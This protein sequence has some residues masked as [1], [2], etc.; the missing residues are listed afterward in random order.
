VSDLDP[1]EDRGG[2]VEGLEAHPRPSD[3]L[4]EPVILFKS[5]VEIFNL[6]G[7]DDLPLPSEFQG[8]IHGHQASQ[9]CATLA[10]DHPVWHSSYESVS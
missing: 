3:P 1:C 4:D 6:P 9:V 2:A 10:D 7:R 8:H 5:I